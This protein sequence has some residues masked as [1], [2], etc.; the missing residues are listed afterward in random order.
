[1]KVFG[2]RGLGAILKIVLQISF[3]FG[4]IF[5][6]GLPYFIRFI[7]EE[8]SW[9]WLVVMPAGALFL[10]IVYQFI[11]MFASLEEHNPFNQKNIKRLKITMWSSFAI[12]ILILVEMVLVYFLYFDKNIYFLGF[13]FLLF[14]G[15][16]I[17]LHILKELFVQ[18]I[19][20][21]EENEL[22]I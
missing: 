22:T 3:V 20:L 19:T 1:M 16:S 8:W 5:L 13:L 7:H 11:G 18:A 2:S 9:Y 6:C 4:I 12:A 14:L 15:V 10:L 17:A 21:K